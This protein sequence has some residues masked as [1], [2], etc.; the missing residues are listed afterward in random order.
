MRHVIRAALPDAASAY[1]VKR[2][3][4]IGK[5][6]QSSDFNIEADWKSARQTKALRSVLHVLQAMMGPRE[7]CMYCVDSHGSDIE[8]FRP[9]ARFPRHAY[10]WENMLLCCA[11]CGRLKGDRFPLAGRRPLLIDPTS[12]DPWQHLDFDP[13]TGALTARFDVHADD[14]SAKGSKTVEVLC[15]DR[16]EAMA[17]GYLKSF[18][19]LA[20]ELQNSFAALAAGGKTAQELAVSLES[21]DDHGLLPWCLLGSGRDMPPF[22]EFRVEYP[23]AWAH[24]VAVFAGHPETAE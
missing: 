16:R 8:H 11:E 5:R 7:R 13:D 21:A 1:L 9:K 3:R 24:C 14:W 20:I 6:L 2:R 4:A 19:R 18:R 23:D 22:S 10:R 12:E 15:L 17:A